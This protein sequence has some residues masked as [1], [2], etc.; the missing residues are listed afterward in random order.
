MLGDHP[1]LAP[2]V[3]AQF[4]PVQDWPVA[5]SQWTT[6]RSTQRR[7][8]QPRPIK[9]GNGIVQG[10]EPCDDGNKLAGDGCDLCAIEPADEA[11]ELDTDETAG[12][13]SDEGASGCECRVGRQPR[14][15][16]PSFVLLALLAIR[17]RFG[18]DLLPVLG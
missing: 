4:N 15:L 10:S 13:G 17:R 2:D 3:G 7:I 5:L 11:D 8:F 12:V 6:P 16:A 14:N 9:C 1:S 18:G